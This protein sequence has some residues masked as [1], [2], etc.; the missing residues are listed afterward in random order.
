M[1]PNHNARI[2]HLLERHSDAVLTEGAD[3]TAALH[4]R[5][6][7]LVSAQQA[8]RAHRAVNQWTERRE[9][10]QEAG[11]T[12]LHLRPAAGVDMGEML[13]GLR[14][15]GEGP[16]AA[17][18]N[19][20]LQA[21]PEYGGVPWNLP[22]PT[23]PIPRPYAEAS[24][25]GRRPLV[26]VLDTGIVAHPWFTD[27]D[28]F[29]QV[30]PD[31]MDPVPDGADYEPESQT[32]HG[33]FVA[34]V[35]LRS[36]PS[37]HLM[38]ERVLDDDGVSDELNLLSHLSNLHRRLAVAGDSVD[39]INMSLGGYTFDDQPS[40]LLSDAL[41]RFGKHTVVVVAAGNFGANRQYWPAALKRCVAVG[42]L[43]SDGEQRA[44]FSNHG[45]WVDACTVGADIVGPY[46]TDR[47]P[48][49]RDFGGYAQWSGTSFAAPHVAGA[50]AALVADKQFTAVEAADFLLDPATRPTRADCGVVVE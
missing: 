16:I 6:Q 49:G 3:G 1:S 26:A 48:D 10:F 13:A 24:N 8:D 4:R 22:Q 18:F 2:E 20:L 23:A 39:V 32:G 47:T 42:A 36:A 21:A 5:N 50:I 44:G 11:V 41:A 34:G 40:P 12:R 7:I 37:A 43:D 9:D 14:N 46:I 19:H 31:Q 15:H 30:A 28:W 25:A 17:S 35:L 33:T 27:T 45:W 38:I 29:A